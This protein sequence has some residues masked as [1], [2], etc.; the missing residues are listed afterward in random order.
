MAAGNWFLPMFDPIADTFDSL[1]RRSIFCLMATLCIALRANDNSPTGDDLHGLC[2]QETRRLAAQSLF[3]NPARFESV[4]AMCLLSAY[5]DKAWF[6]IG[7]AYAMAVDLDLDKALPHLLNN[8]SRMD[9]KQCRLLARQARTWLVLHHLERE[10]AFGTSR[11]SR[12]VP[13][14]RTALR[15]FL[16]LPVASASDLR[17]VDTIE[18][19]QLRGMSNSQHGADSR[20]TLTGCRRFPSS[21]IEFG[22]HFRSCYA[23]GQA[24][25]GSDAR[26]A[27]LLG[28]AA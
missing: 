21:G 10:I 7:H 26:M 12:S 9:R 15:P 11:M 23:K 18:L 14:D 8:E 19:V 27:G 4:Q 20:L 2:L 22:D 1:R 16:R 25:G 6:A 5:A 13:I 24:V 28:P 3:E 17:I